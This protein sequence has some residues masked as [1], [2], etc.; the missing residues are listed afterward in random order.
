MLLL[1]S[2]AAGF[3]TAP[4]LLLPEQKRDIYDRYGKDGLMGAG[5]WVSSPMYLGLVQLHLSCLCCGSEPPRAPCPSVGSHPELHLMLSLFPPAGP[6]GSRTNAGAP[7][8]TFTFRSAHDVFREFFGGRDP[9]ADLFGVCGVG[10]SR[11]LALRHLTGPGAAAGLRNRVHGW[12]RRGVPMAVP[13]FWLI[14]L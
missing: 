2:L 7:E 8:F 13:C 6:G 5:E 10:W 11:G 4:S 3:P 1:P 12:P 14:M 9:F